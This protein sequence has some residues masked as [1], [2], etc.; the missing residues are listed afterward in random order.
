MDTQAPY[1]GKNRMY[2]YSNERVCMCC[3]V[4]MF[5]KMSK[6]TEGTKHIELG[7]F[8]DSRRCSLG[9]LKTRIDII[10]IVMEKKK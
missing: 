6:Y 4:H 9:Y 5:D 2:L 10:F 8:A 1:P 7:P 3:Y